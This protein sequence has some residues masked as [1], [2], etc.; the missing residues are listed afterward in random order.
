MK[1]KDNANIPNE[2]TCNTKHLWKRNIT[3]MNSQN[4]QCLNPTAR[5]GV[6]FLL[7][8]RELYFFFLSFSS[9]IPWSQISVSLF[10]LLFTQYLS[11][12]G[13]QQKFD[14]IRQHTLISAREHYFQ[15]LSIQRYTTWT[16]QYEILIAIQ[17][18]QFTDYTFFRGIPEKERIKIY[19]Q[20]TSIYL[21]HR[22]R[23]Y[24]KVESRLSPE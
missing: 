20:K 8:I 12:K 10:L 2:S 24:T 1:T 23:L 21:I 3:K 15:L 7:L 22:D 9:C 5:K 14:N 4:E 16:N 19:L 13:K 11:H 17:L 18:A 6:L